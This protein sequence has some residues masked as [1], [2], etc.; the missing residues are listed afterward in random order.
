MTETLPIVFVVDGD[1]SVRRAI[2]RLWVLLAF[3][4]TAAVLLVLIPNWG[5]ALGRGFS[6][7]SRRPIVFFALLVAISALTYVPLALGYGPL[8]WFGPFFLCMGASAIRRHRAGA[9]VKKPP[10]P[11]R[12]S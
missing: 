3:D 1:P 2:Q 4:C 10:G 12:Q 8:Y 11:T 7:V 6:G 5:E 9:R